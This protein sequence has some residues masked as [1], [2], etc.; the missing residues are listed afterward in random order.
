MVSRIAAIVLVGVLACAP[1]FAQ[2]DRLPVPGGTS[3]LRA[4]TDMPAW[5]PD[6]MLLVEAARSWYAARDS[7]LNPEP[8][9]R[10]LIEYVRV[11][12]EPLADGPP[13]P[14]DAAAWRT[15][16]DCRA[17]CSLATALV[18]NRT[19]MLM[20]HGLVAMDT[21]TQS[22]MKAHPALLRN[23]LA[24]G[25]AAFAFAA[26]FVH[27]R[28]NVVTLPGGDGLR[29]AWSSVVGEN[30]A[31][32]EPF[33]RELM[34]REGGRIAWLFSALA[35][36]D[37]AH[38]RF[39]LAGGEPAL[40]VLARHAASSSPEWTI[41]ERPFWRTPF[42]FTLVLALTE[43][44]DAG[45]PKGSRR[46][47]REVFR[48]DDLSKWSTDSGEPVTVADLLDLVFDHPYFARDR[49]EIFC[50]GQR[51][52]GVERDEAKAGLMLRGARRHP[53][54]AL[55]LDRIGVSSADVVLSLHTASARV[56]ER[57]PSGARG[58]LGGWQGALA[59]VERA[60]LS[61]GLDAAGV[62]SALS[63]LGAL[64]LDDPRREL[65]HWFMESFIGPLARRPGAPPDAEQL[66]LQVMSG[67]LT[68]RGPA[69]EPSFIWEDLAYSFGAPASLARRME[70]ARAAQRSASIEDA[71]I[72]WHVAESGGSGDVERL[73]ARL[74]DVDVPPDAQDLAHR[75]ERAKADRD[76]SALKRDAR[77]AAEAIVIASLP[78]LAYAPH[79]AVTETPDLGADVAYRH[80]FYAADD[81]PYARQQRP[82]AVARG[83]AAAG[84]EW[85]VQGSL[86][87]LDLALA[88]WYLRRNSEPAAGQPMFD[89]GDMT[90][91]AQVAAMARSGGASGLRLSEAAAAVEKGRAVAAAAPSM[92][93]LDGLLEEAG[94]DPWRR[95]A[96]SRVA[97]EPAALAAE[98][99]YAE[100][101]R[102]GGSPGLLSPH[103]AV[104]GGA[105]FGAVPRSPL[106]MEGRRS[107]GVIGASA[108]DAQLRVAMFLRA[109]KLP[110]RLFGDLA[111]GLIDELIKTTFAR[112]PDD[113]VAYATSVAHIDDTRLEEHLLAL[114][115]DGTLARP[116]QTH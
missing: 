100:A 89:E 65:T 25:A 68:P 19:A 23:L 27:V 98:L 93:I 86:L 53:A 116:D 62:S 21:D 74:R 30:P 24:N 48:S 63:G 94:I 8:G 22:W 78:A 46:F 57:D 43:L 60:A 81:G 104:D 11:S 64:R 45:V 38:Q 28:G 67:R 31:R 97:T 50:L 59:V 15:L 110:D 87:L 76:E 52:P 112:R 109:R 6:D 42:D 108:V 16:L 40:S 113:F 44:T 36:L 4:V 77:R 3:A 92:A 114:V 73:A 18:T 88:D 17:P 37:P 106:L 12:S 82:W 39:A 96:L 107:A 9:L 115:A 32:P 49:W 80:E 34:R 69:H 72:A 20:Y 29:G 51:L 70:Q 2:S 105:H 102:M 1:A 55:M 26:P 91:L 14:L 35:Q 41:S 79:L 95:W 56:F 85:H 84:V 61:G 101:W 7:V 71:R 47:W 66:V 10:R 33:I 5:V 111:A 83:H 58:E 75:L 99:E 13:L 90:A 54:L 103:P